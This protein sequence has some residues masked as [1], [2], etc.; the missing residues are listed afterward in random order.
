MEFSFTED[1]LYWK[2]CA[3]FCDDAVMLFGADSGFGDEEVSYC[4]VCVV[5]G[6]GHPLRRGILCHVGKQVVASLLYS[7]K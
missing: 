5:Y 6:L 3:G 4:C 1:A 7:Q 2:P